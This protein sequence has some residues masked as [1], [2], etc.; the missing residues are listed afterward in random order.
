MKF[1]PFGATFCVA[2]K[3]FIKLSSMKTKTLMTSLFIAASLS[4]SA[5]TIEKNVSHFK[6]V[7]ASPRINLV[8]VAGENE[9][10]KISYANVD[11]SKI[12]IVV[13]NNAL[14]IYLDGSKY[15][16]KHERIKKY[17]WVANETNYLN[18]TI[19]ASLT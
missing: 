14:H 9:S 4:G 2:M 6:K 3:S 10:G 17:G 8:M 7:I 5:Q 13:K 16:E 15:P 19:P 11:A 18:S 1:T 12:N